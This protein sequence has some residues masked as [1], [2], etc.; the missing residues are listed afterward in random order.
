VSDTENDQCMQVDLK[1]VSHDDFGDLQ[2]T[3]IIFTDL[4]VF[5]KC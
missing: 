4:I 1:G 2:I 5:S 3:G